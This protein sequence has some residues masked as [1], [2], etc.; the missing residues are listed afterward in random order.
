M[1]NLVARLL[2]LQF[3][4]M[5]GCGKKK[6]PVSITA[7]GNLWWWRW[8][9]GWGWGGHLCVNSCDCPCV[10]ASICAHERRT[11]NKPCCCRWGWGAPLMGSRGRKASFDQRPRTLGGGAGGGE[12]GAAG[13]PQ[14]RS[15]A[16]RPRT[17]VSLSLRWDPPPWKS[18][19]LSATNA[20]FFW[21][22]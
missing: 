11:P 5:H 12:W 18:T 22:L 19:C 8:W 1:C 7:P 4:H 16:V 13:Y 9:W 20:F 6:H 14:Q 2:I 10:F 15:S 3:I 21:I 17:K